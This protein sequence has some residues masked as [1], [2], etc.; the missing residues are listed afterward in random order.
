[1]KMKISKECKEQVKKLLEEFF[2]YNM[3][4]KDIEEFIYCIQSKETSFFNYGIDKYYLFNWLI[5][6]QIHKIWIK[7]NK[8]PFI[9]NSN[10][11][12]YMKN[13]ATKKKSK[14]STTKS[15]PSSHTITKTTTTSQIR[16]LTC[17]LPYNPI[18]TITKISKISTPIV[19]L[20]SKIKTQKSKNN[21]MRNFILK[22]SN[23]LK[24]KTS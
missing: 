23:E 20:Q 18:I 22:I 8:L 6:D 3:D 17:Y 12:N 24:R 10:H 7:E 4:E 13:I 19:S 15:L 11:S 2:E 16:S 14:N 21:L 1:M 9:P 5:Y